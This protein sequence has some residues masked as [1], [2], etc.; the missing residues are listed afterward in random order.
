MLLREIRGAI[1][2]QFP[3]ISGIPRATILIQK[4]VILLFESYCLAPIPPLQQQA[5][6]IF[7]LRK[8]DSSKLRYYRLNNFVYR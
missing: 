8:I 4:G 7:L 6:W 3:K 2:E 5:L 1:Q